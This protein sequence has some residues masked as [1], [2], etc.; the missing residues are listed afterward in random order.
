MANNKPNNDKFRVRATTYTS[1]KRTND[2]HVG[3]LV[4]RVKGEDVAA[5]IKELSAGGY[6]DNGATIFLNTY[7]NVSKIEGKE[8]DKYFSSTL[9]VVLTDGDQPAVKKASIGSQIKQSYGGN[10][11]IQSRR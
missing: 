5:L 10:S 6:S 1:D 3:N 2:D 7:E 9:S 8:G 11:K 4:L